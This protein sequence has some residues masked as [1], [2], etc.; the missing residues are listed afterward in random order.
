MTLKLQYIFLLLTSVL[1]IACKEPAPKKPAFRIENDI[2]VL[3]GRA[4]VVYPDGKIKTDSLNPDSVYKV[5]GEMIAIWNK[6]GAR[7]SIVAYMVHT[8]VVKFE[9][10]DPARPDYE[11]DMA[12]EGYEVLYFDYSKEPHLYASVHDFDFMQ[13]VMGIDV[14]KPNVEEAQAIEPEQGVETEASKEEI[15]RKEQEAGKP[16]QPTKPNERLDLSK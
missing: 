10:N 12:K 1:L 11:M 9:F 5:L 16:V 6:N 13:L 8:P 3:S 2:S 7:D 15:L 4:I 14:N